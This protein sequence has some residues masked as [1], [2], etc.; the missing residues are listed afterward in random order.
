MEA[1][2]VFLLQAV[3]ISLSGVMAP[4]PMTT[5][6]LAAGAKS[7]HAG[8]R[9]A[10][11]HGIVEFPLMLLIMAGMGTLLASERVQ[12]GIG[13][14]GGAF[15]ILLGVQMLRNLGAESD[16]AGPNSGRGPIWT[17]II[18][19]G[20]NPYFLVWWAT[21]GLA[22][23]SRASELGVLAFGL[24]AVAHWLCDLVWLEA[25]TMAT[26]KGS[27]L[28]G[29]RGQRAVLTVCALALLVFGV[30]FIHDAAGR[31]LGR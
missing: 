18:L 26:F 13:L 31:V 2:I 23:A 22:L 7:R 6:A 8:A 21:V 9:M 16:A 27:E 20:G 28:L 25:L 11:G 24:F 19:S 30:M 12:I 15:L 3:I 17:G 29:R 4:G 14:A 10:L 1:L 5:A